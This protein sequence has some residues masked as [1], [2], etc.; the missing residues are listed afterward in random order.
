MRP[1][2]RETNALNTAVAIWIPCRTTNYILFEDRY[3]RTLIKTM[4][5]LMRKGVVYEEGERYLTAVKA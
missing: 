4:E 2:R 5:S 3:E 1:W